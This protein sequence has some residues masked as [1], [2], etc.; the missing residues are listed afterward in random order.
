MKNCRFDN[1]CNSRTMELQRFNCACGFIG[2]SVVMIVVK[3]MNDKSRLG[4]IAMVVLLFSHPLKC[5][6][7][8][9]YWANYVYSQ[10]RG[11]DRFPACFIHDV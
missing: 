3:G 4:K 2:K 5:H 8:P 11:S 7:V 6:N 10:E 1:S 9:I